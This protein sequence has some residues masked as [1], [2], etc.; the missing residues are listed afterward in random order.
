M[1][2]VTAAIMR[3]D[4]LRTLQAYYVEKLAELRASH[5][6]QMRTAEAA[7]LDAIRAVDQQR[8]SADAAA[9][10]TRAT[11]L[12]SQVALSADVVRNALDAKVGPILEALA[13]VQRAQYESGGRQQQV[14]ETRETKADGRGGNT[15]MIML[16]SVT[17]TFLIVVIAGVSLYATLKK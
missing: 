2:L 12:A 10:E 16:A 7:R 3:Q 4:D 9:A 6:E 1:D 17:F 11:A 13:A 15:L 14:V 8:V 5:M